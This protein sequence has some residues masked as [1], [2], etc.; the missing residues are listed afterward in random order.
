[1]AGA[2]AAGAAHG[3]AR[4]APAVPAPAPTTGTANTAGKE[5]LVQAF[6][7]GDR[8]VAKLAKWRKGYPGTIASISAPGCNSTGMFQYAVLFD[9]GD[10]QNVPQTGVRKI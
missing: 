3:S 5:G 2:P 1:M 10:R 8:V 4:P 9:D 6:H 7:R